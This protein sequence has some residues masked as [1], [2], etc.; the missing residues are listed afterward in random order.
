MGSHGKTRVAGSASQVEHDGIGN[1]GDLGAKYLQIFSGSVSHALQVGPRR[2]TE[3]LHYKNVMLHGFSPD[4]ETAEPQTFP[5]IIA[6]HAITGRC[7]GELIQIWRMDT[8][9]DCA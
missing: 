9:I 4:L 6:D 5:D 3:L 7:S 1:T 2:G 8:T